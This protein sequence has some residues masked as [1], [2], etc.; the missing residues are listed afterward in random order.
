M[1][2]DVEIPYMPASLYSTTPPFPGPHR[3]KK[4]LS[5]ALNRQASITVQHMLGEFSARPSSIYQ[6]E[7]ED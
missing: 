1:V 3:K 7:E 2:E 5:Y 6:K 4:G